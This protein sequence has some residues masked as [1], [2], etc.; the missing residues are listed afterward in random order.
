MKLEDLKEKYGNK[1]IVKNNQVLGI[2]ECN[3]KGEGS[4]LGNGFIT[5]FT[6]LYPEYTN[7]IQYIACSKI[8]NLSI[9]DESE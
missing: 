7:N 3:G 2:C 8:Q 4:C 9:K 5:T 1:L 6:G